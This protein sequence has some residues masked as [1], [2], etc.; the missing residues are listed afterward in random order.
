MFIYY[1]W[2]ATSDNSKASSRNVEVSIPYNS[3]I[4]PPGIYSG[5]TQAFVYDTRHTKIFTAAFSIQL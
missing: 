1:R 2:K 4:T 5:E 3:A